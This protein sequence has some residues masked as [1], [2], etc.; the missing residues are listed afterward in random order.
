MGN[1]YYGEPQFVRRSLQNSSWTYLG[2]VISDA[3]VVGLAIASGGSFVA[4]L[5]V[6]GICGEQALDGQQDGF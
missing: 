4:R 5:V 1:L 2:V 3:F 6:E